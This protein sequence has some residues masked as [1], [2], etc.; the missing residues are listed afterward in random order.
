MLLHLHEGDIHKIGG[1]RFECCFSTNKNLEYC[2]SKVGHYQLNSQGMPDGVVVMKYIIPQQY[3]DNLQNV[4]GE[5]IADDLTVGDTSSSPTKY[6]QHLM[7]RL[8]NAVSYCSTKW[9]G[10]L[11]QKKEVIRH[12]VDGDK[13]DDEDVDEIMKKLHVRKAAKNNKLYCAM[14]TLC[15]CTKAFGTVR[16]S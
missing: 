7:A 13:N 10:L 1:F 6:Q 14:T 9:I 12:I 11:R 16:R 5:V 15:H 8:M 3:V 2:A 4:V